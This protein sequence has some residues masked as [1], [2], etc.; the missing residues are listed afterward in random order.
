MLHGACQAGGAPETELPVQAFKGHAVFVWKENSVYQFAWLPDT[1]VLISRK[2][3]AEKP[4]VTENRVTAHIPKMK[5]LDQFVKLFLI[6]NP[7]SATFMDNQHS[8]MRPRAEFS[9]LVDRLS[10][11][12]KENGVEIQFLDSGNNSGTAGGF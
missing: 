2:L 6:E 10:A 8:P 1:N 9:D 4:P 12:A 5:G 11:L 7:H 3:V